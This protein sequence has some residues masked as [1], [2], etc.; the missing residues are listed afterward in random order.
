MLNKKPIFISKML[1]IILFSLINLFVTHTAH[2]TSSIY[3]NS[4]IHTTI[5]IVY[6]QKPEFKKNLFLKPNSLQ[7]AITASIEQKINKLDTTY[8]QCNICQLLSIILI[9]ACILY[10][11]VNRLKILYKPIQYSYKNDIYN[12]YLAWL[13]QKNHSPPVLVN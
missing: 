7:Q 13:S 5:C 3:Q 11:I 9:C 8:N 10:L 12:L 2:I 6:K 4:K 1:W